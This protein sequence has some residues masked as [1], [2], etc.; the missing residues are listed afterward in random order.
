MAKLILL[1]LIVKFF[2]QKYAFN[3][4]NKFTNKL[5]IA[6]T[7]IINLFYKNISIYINVLKESLLTDYLQ[8]TYLTKF[9]TQ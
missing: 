1:F 7:Y 5:V 8:K 3:F 9:L 4:L 2:L 6:Y